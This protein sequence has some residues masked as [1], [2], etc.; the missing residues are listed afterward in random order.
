[1]INLPK[2][3]NLDVVGK[4]VLVR[5]DLDVGDKLEPGDDI[6][7]STLIPT[8]KYLSEKQAKAILLGHFGRPDKV[9]DK[10][11]LSLSGVVKRLSELLGKEIKFVSELFGE[12]SNSAIQQLNNG[13]LLCLENLRFDEREEKNEE[14]FT[15]RLAGFGNVYVNEAFSASHREHAS[16]VGIPKYLPHAAGLHFV[17]EVEKLSQVLENPKHPVVVLLSGLKKDKLDFVESFGKFAD[18]ILLAGRLPDYMGDDKISVRLARPDDKVIS[19]DLIQDKEDITIHSIEVFEGI[20][21]TAE[22]I[23]VSGP[24]GKFE[25]EGHR[26]GTERVLKAVA[27]SSA[28]KVAGGGDTEQAIAMFNLR[29]KFDWI[30]VGGGAS[31]EFLAKGTLPGIEAL[32]G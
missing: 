25:D 28:F 17:E 30:S 16:V 8:L 12:Q 1:M 13:E 26:Q 9:E 20:I 32:R 23:V 11:S 7:L 2:V 15:K 19:A 18:K 22:T 27:N 10:T 21:K 3:E 24:M 14:E 5:A 29:D 4:K 6:K 31:M